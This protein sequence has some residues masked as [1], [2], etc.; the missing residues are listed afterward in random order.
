[1]DFANGPGL[2]N[3]LICKSSEVSEH[4]LWGLFYPTATDPERK[5]YRTTSLT[6]NQWDFYIV[7]IDNTGTISLFRNGIDIGDS[8]VEDT[9]TPGTT[10]PDIERTI[11][12]MGRSHWDESYFQG[13][14]D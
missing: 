14:I 2:G 5:I 1:M 3:I 8:F 12:W 11:S 6:L 9:T 13:A 4:Y 7:T 10:L